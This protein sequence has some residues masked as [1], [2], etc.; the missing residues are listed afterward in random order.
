VVA[1]SAGAASCRAVFITAGTHSITVEYLGDQNN[2]SRVSSPI[3]QTVNAASTATLLAGA[4]SPASVGQTVL[5][6]ALVYPTGAGTGVVSGAIRFVDGTSL[7]ACNGAASPAPVPADGL[8]LATCALKYVATGTHSVSASFVGSVNYAAS[9]SSP[10]TEVVTTTTSTTVTASANP[11]SA[12]KAVTYVA[13]VVAGPGGPTPT[14]NVEF[15]D[16]GTA[17]ALCG[18][19]SGVALGAAGTASCT[20]TYPSGGTHTIVARYLGSTYLN[21]STAATLA[22]VI[23]P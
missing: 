10:V 23:H 12:G 14:G 3:V 8:G 18:H 11:G 9:T 7:L 5:Y 21:P 20:E 13:K 15:V 2:L 17:V 16:N 22:E 4:P 19:S 6:V 1:L